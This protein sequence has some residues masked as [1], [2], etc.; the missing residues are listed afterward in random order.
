MTTQRKIDYSKMPAEFQHLPKSEQSKLIY[1][2]NDL[3]KI[4]KK[5]PPELMDSF[6]KKVAMLGSEK[7]D[8]TDFQSLFEETKK[9]A[10]EA[11]EQD[12]TDRQNFKNKQK[13]LEKELNEKTKTTKC[14]C[15][16]LPLNLQK[17]GVKC[18]ICREAK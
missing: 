4:L 2:A 12:R 10:E 14:N 13:Q 3:E 17:K 1:M 9:I 16:F 11:I 18:S 15:D 7:K 5:L 6:T 8:L